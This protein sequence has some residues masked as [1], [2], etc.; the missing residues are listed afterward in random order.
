MMSEPQ[1]IYVGH[2]EPDRILRIVEPDTTLPNYEGE[3]TFSSPQCRVLESNSLVTIA[4]AGIRGGKTHVG[5]FKTLMYALAHPCGEDEFHAIGS[6]TYQMSKVPVEKMFRLLFDKTIFPICPLIKF[7][8]SEKTFL[9]ACEDGRTTKII[10]RSLHD[11][12]RWRGLKLL[13]CWLDEGA[14]ISKYAWDI[15]QGRLADSNGPCWITTTPAGYNWVFDLY[16]DARNGDTD[17]TVVHWASTEN[18]FAS[19][20][21]LA[22]LMER[23]DPLTYQQEVQARFV[24]G[25]GLIYYTFNR[26]AHLK[27]GVFD[28]NKELWV[29]QDFNVNPMCGIF[30]QPYRNSLR[31][32]GAHVIW[33]RRAAN[34]DTY[35]LATYL[36]QFCK[37]K[38]YPKSKIT[39][40]AD[41]AGKAR[42][43]AG[44]SDFRILREAGYR[45]DAP[46]ANPLVKDR[47]NCVN[48]LFAPKSRVPRLVVD[49]DCQDF[50]KGIEKQAWDSETDPPQPDKTQG[51]DHMN[52][53]FGYMCWRRWPLKKQM[54]T[55]M[56]RAA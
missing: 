17:I 50:I 24:R 10:V 11:P 44:K 27:K 6:P 33:T 2:L 51:Y 37:E 38:N 13:S 14:Y 28:K 56:A 32:E 39:I 46:K 23:F 21:G 26:T 30:A 35:A 47:I 20:E 29:G 15:V 7:V 22:G 34:S 25:S 12:D 52:D 43:T 40:Y 48:G 49:P 41:A 1:S 31:Q 42:S 45:V 54:S 53:G 9:L 3:V 8:K 18:V 55:G 4:L 5:A 19:A 36:D 16:D